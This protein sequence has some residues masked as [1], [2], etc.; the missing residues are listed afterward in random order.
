LSYSC[1]GD[2]HAINDWQN[3]TIN[4]SATQISVVHL[5]CSPTYCSS[6][7]FVDNEMWLQK[8][9]SP[10]NPPGYQCPC[11]WVEAG[12]STYS[13]DHLT[14]VDYFWA[15]KRPI[16]GYVE[17][18]LASVP[19]GDYGNYASVYINRSSSSS[20]EVTINSPGYYFD[21]SS[22]NNSMSPNDINIGQ[23]L[24]GT[25]GALAPNADLIDNAYIDTSNNFYY[26]TT[27]G[28][29]TEDGPPYAWWA[30]YPTPPNSSTGGDLVTACC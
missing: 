4:G 1:A 3:G 21:G 30:I 27:M 19:S 20:F 29:R 6:G 24:Y 12:Y 13:N 18:D 26:Q 14:R 8:L 5:T 17:H 25:N 22:T 15:D 10:N 23:E 11:Y 9:T 16:Y 7:G 28:N 2:C